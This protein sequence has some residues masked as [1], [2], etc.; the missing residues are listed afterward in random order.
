MRRLAILGLLAVAACT[1]SQEVAT[2]P[3]AKA[4]VSDPTST[5]PEVATSSVAAT[6][7]T[8][9]TLAPLVGLAYQ[10]ID[11]VEF[12]IQLVARPGDDISYLATKSGLVWGMVDGQILDQPVLDISG[13]VRDSG[14]QGLLSIAL[15]PTERPFFYLHYSDASGDTTVS[16]FRF[17][18]PTES[19]PESERILF[20][21]DQPAANHNGGMIMFHPV[22][23][24]LLLGLGDGGGGGDRF[25][26]G[27]N[28]DTLLGGLV[29]LSVDGELDPILF[30]SGLRN[31]WR[32]WID[33]G[34]LYIADVGQN[35]FEEISV[36]PLAPDLN[37]GWPITEG[38]HCFRPNSGCDSTG[39][40]LPVVEVAH[41]DAGTCSITGGVVYRGSA[42]PELGG[43]YLYSDYCGGYL[44][45]LQLAEEGVVEHDWTEQVGEVGRVASF[46]VDGQGEV[47]VMTTDT[48]FKLEATR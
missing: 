1:G 16:E 38:L 25:G 18:T 20:V 8:P 10:E 39:T 42:I 46:G 13:R 43:H 5:Q 14:E 23:G 26:N 31:P 28:T 47:Y 37:F 24:T 7:A 29:A 3:A 35:A 27:Q 30:A 41:G 40:I 17:E 21:Q 33:G 32:F 4:L 19:D 15:H 11:R 12:P 34:N 48:V 22:D 2:T 36:T 45:S 44:R 9:T 6:T